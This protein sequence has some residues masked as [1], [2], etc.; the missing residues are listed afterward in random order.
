MRR[1]IC[2]YIDNDGLGETEQPEQQPIQ[3]QGTEW[4]PPL[5]VIVDIIIIII[6]ITRTTWYDSLMNKKDDNT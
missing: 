5:S 4:N 1:Q 2:K 6:Y 3:F